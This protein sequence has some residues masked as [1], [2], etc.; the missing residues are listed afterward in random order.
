LLLQALLIFVPFLQSIKRRAKTNHP[1]C[2]LRQQKIL[3]DIVT[4]HEQ[5][6]P[7]GECCGAPFWLRETLSRLPGC[8]A[9]LGG[10]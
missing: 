8:S 2:I 3:G 7:G 9:K 4:I 5:V 10:T 6:G 1:S